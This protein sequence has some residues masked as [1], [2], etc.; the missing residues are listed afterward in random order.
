MTKKK[1]QF[2]K[3][4]ETIDEILANPQRSQILNNQFFA[5]NSFKQVC[6]MTM[7]RIG[8]GNLVGEEDILYN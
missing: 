1:I 2:S 3:E 6:K 4:E 5:K 8:Q 7:A